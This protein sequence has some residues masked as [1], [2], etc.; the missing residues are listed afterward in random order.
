MN[1]S[2]AWL[3]PLIAGAVGA[4]ALATAAAL[5]RREVARL[6]KAMRPLRVPE[7]SRRGRSL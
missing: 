4:G 3:A 7:S 5:V 2:P 6:Q 1:L